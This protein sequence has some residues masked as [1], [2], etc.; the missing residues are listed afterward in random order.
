M[1]DHRAHHGGG[2]AL[3]DPENC[4]Q[5]FER[6]HAATFYNRAY[7]C[8]CVYAENTPQFLWAIRA[9]TRV[10]SNLSGKP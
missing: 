2:G 3:N 4:E 8:V 5:T 10:R 7:V 1:H 9:R 6:A